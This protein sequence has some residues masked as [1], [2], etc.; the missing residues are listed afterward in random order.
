MPRH[1]LRMP[2]SRRMR[3]RRRTAWLAAGLSL[4]MASPARPAV[5]FSRDIRPILSDQCFACHG[6]D[7]RARKAKL[8][9]D[10]REGALRPGAPEDA[11]IVPGEPARSP[12]VSRITTTDPDDRMP[13]PATG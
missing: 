3:N 13:P 12:L 1:Q 6:P 10:T 8:R 2:G 4:W 9:L 5:D 11:V 7:E